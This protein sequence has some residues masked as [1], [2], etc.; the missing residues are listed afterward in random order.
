MLRAL[1]DR[2]DATEALPG[3]DVPV[4]VVCGEHDAITPPAE[5]RRLAEV[6]PRG[7][8]V[9]IAGAGHLSALERPD[10]FAAAVRA[11][12]AGA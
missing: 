11:F 1:R 8:Y 5:C 10:A 7:R 12:A 2:R 4:L 9:E 6:L 3:I